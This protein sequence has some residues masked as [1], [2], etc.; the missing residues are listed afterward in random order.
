MAVPGG[1]DR[2]HEGQKVPSRF[3]RPAESRSLDIASWPPAGAEA[4]GAFA[5]G[6]FAAAGLAGWVF[7]GLVLAEAGTAMTLWH[8][9]HLT[10]LPAMVSGTFNATPH[11][12][13]TRNGIRRP[14]V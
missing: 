8:L 13:L 2:S 9:G 12:Q 3:L 14:F 10:P 1:K 11:W 4:A 6:A 5:A 7:G